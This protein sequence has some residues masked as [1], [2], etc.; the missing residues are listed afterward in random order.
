MVDLAFIFGIFENMAKII[1][2][3]WEAF[4]DPI[5]PFWIFLIVGFAIVFLSSKISRFK[6]G[7]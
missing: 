4:V 2:S 7:R 5:K 1:S 3:L 6:F